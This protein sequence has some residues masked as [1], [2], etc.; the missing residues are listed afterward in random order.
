[1]KKVA[2]YGLKNRSALIRLAQWLS[3]RYEIC[4]WIVEDNKVNLRYFSGKPVISIEQIRKGG[5][6]TMNFLIILLWQKHL[7]VNK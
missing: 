1:M 5:Q 4:A 3:D 7:K 2:F 6:T